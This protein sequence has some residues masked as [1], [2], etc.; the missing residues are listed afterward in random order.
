MFDEIR[1]LDKCNLL[2]G[3][4]CCPER[5]GLFLWLEQWDCQIWPVWYPNEEDQSGSVASEIWITCLSLKN[6]LC[7]SMLSMLLIMETPP[8]ERPYS[9]RFSGWWAEL[10]D[11]IVL[12]CQDLD[13]FFRSNFCHIL[14]ELSFTCPFQGCLL[15]RLLG[16]TTQLRIG[17]ACAARKFFAVGS[18]IS[19]CSIII[20][21]QTTPWHLASGTCRS[22]LFATGRFLSASLLL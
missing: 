7:R 5:L 9:R 13:F 3:V 4:V 18:W 8:T 19:T 11:L 14:G 21:G 17:Y 16:A 20:S 2:L 10:R 22:C 6:S 12:M 15:L 1:D